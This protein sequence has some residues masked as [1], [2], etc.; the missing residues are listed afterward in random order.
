ML[1]SEFAKFQMDGKQAPS[2]PD[3]VANGVEINGLHVIFASN[4]CSRRRN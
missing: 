4:T 1:D 3:A 2:G